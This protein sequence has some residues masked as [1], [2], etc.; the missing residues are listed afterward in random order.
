MYVPSWQA[1]RAARMRSG[2]RCSHARCR[3]FYRECATSTCSDLRRHASYSRDQFAVSRK[4]L[5][6]MAGLDM[7]LQEVLRGEITR[8][9]RA[10]TAGDDSAAATAFSALY[11]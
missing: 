11:E 9:P 2:S 8:H 7:A 10:W 3:L 6:P 1:T 5:A 4:K